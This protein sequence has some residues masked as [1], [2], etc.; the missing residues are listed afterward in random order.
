MPKLQFDELNIGDN[1]L[2]DIEYEYVE[3]DHIIELAPTD[4]KHESQYHRQEKCKAISSE[5]CEYCD[6]GESCCKEL[7]E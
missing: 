2:K 1:C 5:Y 7:K 6:D 4:I 3:S